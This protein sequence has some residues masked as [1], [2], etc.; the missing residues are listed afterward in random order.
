MVESDP[1]F[2]YTV[3]YIST[4]NGQNVLK[5]CTEIRISAAKTRL[6]FEVL[7][8]TQITSKCY[9]PSFSLG[10]VVYEYA[11]HFSQ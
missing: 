1:S 10:S 9:I 8:A 5:N 6:I 11:N 7:S 2:N 3:Y 4:E